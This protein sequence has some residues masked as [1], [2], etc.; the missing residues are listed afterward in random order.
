MEH[1]NGALSQGQRGQAKLDQLILAGILVATIT[2][3][4]K[5]EFPHKT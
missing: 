1:S 5:E 3:S 2:D 4:N